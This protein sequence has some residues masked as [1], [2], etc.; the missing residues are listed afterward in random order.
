M[1][2]HGESI[3]YDGITWHPGPDGY[4]RS[5]RH[6]LLHR[7]MYTHKV[8][9]IPAGM[10]VHHK[11]HDKRDNRIANF[12][13]LHP[14]EHWHEHGDERG[15]DWHSKG[16]KATWA[17]AQPREYECERCGV[18]FWS[19]A[20]TGARYCSPPCRDAAAPSRAR[21]QRVCCV[22]G[23]GF[24]CQRRAATR[25]CSRKCTATVAYQSRRQGL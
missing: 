11:N 16:G 5:T 7:Y 8:G 22:C 25:T 21:E 19:R 9:S 20:T 6:G 12:A 18:G 15:A 4:Y 2:T 17:K 14:G 24:E 13:L 3:K 1:G 10:Q 23:G